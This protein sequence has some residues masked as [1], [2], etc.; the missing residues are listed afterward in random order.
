MW[1][2]LPAI[3]TVDGT[4][5]HVS[6]RRGGKAYWWKPCSQVTST[7]NIIRFLESK[8]R[9]SF[10][11]AFAKVQKRLSASLCLSVCPSHRTE[12]LGSHWK[13]FHEISYLRIFGKICLETSS[14]IKIWQE[15]RVRY[16]QTNI[17]FWSYLSEFFAEWEIL[18]GCRENQNTHFR[19]NSFFLKSCPLWD[20]VEKYC[21]AGRVTD[22]KMVHSY[23]MLDNSGYR[24]TLI[25][26]T[27][28]W[29]PLQQWLDASASMLRYT[30]TACLVE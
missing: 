25:L 21:R 20:N 23:W 17:H 29:F 12:Q 15:W 4:D 6:S 5:T 3:C 8:H 28:F 11:G 18:Q 27:I 10:L 9:H 30:Y 16:M 26:H 14:F 22:D 24:H 19:F 13:D 2:Q 1:F 7:C